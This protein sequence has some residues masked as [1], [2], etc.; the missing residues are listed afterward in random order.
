[1]QLRRV[2]IPRCARDD[3]REKWAVKP[4]AEEPNPET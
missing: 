3:S 1:M 4:K 2:Q